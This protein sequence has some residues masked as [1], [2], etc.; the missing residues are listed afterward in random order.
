MWLLPLIYTGVSC[1]EKS[2][3][4][5]SVKGP[6]ATPLFEKQNWYYGEDSINDIPWDDELVVTVWNHI[7]E[8]LTF[9]IPP[10]YIYKVV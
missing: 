6:Y 1:S 2:L 8:V 3:I 4:D 10:P 9:L 5:G 7:I